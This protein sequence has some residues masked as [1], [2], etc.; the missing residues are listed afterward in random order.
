MK[1]LL[2]VLL[3]LMLCA[4]LLLTAC[5]KPEVS[6]D[7]VTP[8]AQ[9]ASDKATVINS[10]NKIDLYAMYK[11]LEKG[12]EEVGKLDAVR[13]YDIYALEQ[14][15]GGELTMGENSADILVT[16]KDG[17]VH[18]N[19]VD[20]TPGATGGEEVYAYIT[21]ALDTITFELGKDGKWAPVQYEENAPVYPEYGD[22]FGGEIYP[23]TG[24]AMTRDTASGIGIG[25][26]FGF[27][28][29]ILKRITIPKIA[30]NQLTEKDG[31]LVLSNE[32]FGDLIVANY[33]LLLELLGAEGAPAKEELRTELVESLDMAGLEVAFTANKQVITGVYVTLAPEETETVISFAV[34]LNDT[35]KALERIKV[36]AKVESEFDYDSGVSIELTTTLDGN[37]ITAAKL[38]AEVNTITN[39]YI[40]YEDTDNGYI[41]T[42]VAVCGTYKIEATLSGIANGNEIKLDANLTAKADKAFEVTEIYDYDNGYTVNQKEI[43]TEDYGMD[44]SAALSLIYNDAAQKI[45]ID[46]SFVRADMDMALNG[47]WFLTIAP[48]AG[49][50]PAEI[51]EYINEYNAQ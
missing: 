45:D 31:K 3:A 33:D 41:D 38:V 40:D 16:L 8:P 17:I 28:A 47:T 21:E 10:F 30:E 9:Q 4:S 20:T 14:E 50:I 51:L 15:F 25:N 26:L 22:D 11:V 35:A 39:D 42:Y 24:Y 7:P 18:A 29:E 36:E 1:K 6:D 12:V 43:G 23:S 32:Y 34:E 27:D 2:T 13:N 49:E 46:F 19:L 44:A 37:D 48:N 5:T